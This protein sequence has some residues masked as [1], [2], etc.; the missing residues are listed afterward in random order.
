[1]SNSG[2]WDRDVVGDPVFWK[3]VGQEMGVPEP[4]SSDVLIQFMMSQK[5]QFTPGIG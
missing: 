1:L 3:H 4:V 5:L 2:G